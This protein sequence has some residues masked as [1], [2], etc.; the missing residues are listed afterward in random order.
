MTGDSAQAGEILTTER[1]YI[2]ELL[3]DASLPDVSLARSRVLPGVSTQLHAL[4]VLEWYVIEAGRGLMRV[5][6]APPFSV[7]AGDAIQILPNTHQQISNTG[8]T[9]LLFLCVC[10]PRFTPACYSSRE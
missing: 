6:D 2:R 10:T 5:G 7:S 3:N 1:C 9:D 8:D 4:T